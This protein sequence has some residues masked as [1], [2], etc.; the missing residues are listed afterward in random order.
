VAT[1]V[2]RKTRFVMLAQVDGKDTISVVNALPRQM[3]H[4]PELLRKSLT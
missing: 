3:Q 1:L 2:E 4:L